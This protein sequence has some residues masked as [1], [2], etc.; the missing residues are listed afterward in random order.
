MADLDNYF[1]H[2]WN[3]SGIKRKL[4]FPNAK[5]LFGNSGEQLAN[6]KASLEH[7]TK[8]LDWNR[9]RLKVAPSK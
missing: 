7:A 9:K 3:K 4:P 8:V 5:P 1:G 6:R 2:I